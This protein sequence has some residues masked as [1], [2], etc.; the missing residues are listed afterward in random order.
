MSHYVFVCPCNKRGDKS[1]SLLLKQAYRFSVPCRQLP[2]KS[3]ANLLTI[4]C[5]STLTLPKQNGPCGVTDIESFK[6]GHIL[7]AMRGSMV[8]GNLKQG[9]QGED[10]YKLPALQNYP[11]HE[12]YQ[13]L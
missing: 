10:I 8:L 11:M 9:S 1:A 4:W 7:Q 6:L 13:Q 3:S 2:P 12:E 5:N